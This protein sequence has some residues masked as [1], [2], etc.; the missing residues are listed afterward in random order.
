MNIN[1]F[2]C[3]G[4]FCSIVISCLLARLEKLKRSNLQ[5]YHGGPIKGHL[6]PLKH[7]GTKVLMGIR[8]PRHLAPIETRA[9]QTADLCFFFQSG[10]GY[11]C[12]IFVIFFSVNFFSCYSSNRRRVFTTDILLRLFNDVI[13][14]V[15][16]CY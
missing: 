3:W 11:S 6:G 9:F 7:H 5:L 8:G 13:R 1:F 4:L 10:W 12:E 15:H 2:F 16:N 14:C